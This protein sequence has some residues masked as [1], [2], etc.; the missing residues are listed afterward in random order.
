VSLSLPLCVRFVSAAAW[1][2]F[3]FLCFFWLWIVCECFF[4]GAD[5]WIEE[6]GFRG[7]FSSFVSV[8]EDDKKKKK[9][10][11]KKASGNAFSGSVEFSS[12][13]DGYGASNARKCCWNRSSLHYYRHRCCSSSS[14]MGQSKMQQ[15]QRRFES[16]VVAS[17]V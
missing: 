8:K 15:Q 13:G 16:A 17:S 12:S 9:K 7:A 10:K 3:F 11:K 4:F 5:C 14:S 6:L 2:G 1:L